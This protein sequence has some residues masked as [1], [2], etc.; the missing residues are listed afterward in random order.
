MPR[1]VSRRPGHRP[2]A[3]VG[4][5]APRMPSRCL[6]CLILSPSV[7][8]KSDP[9][10][11]RPFPIPPLLPLFPIHPLCIRPF[12]LQS[13]THPFFLLLIL[14]PSILSLSDPL[15]IRPFPVPPLPIRPFPIPP[16]HPSFPL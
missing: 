12:P 1:S 2:Q 4:V 11:I 9:L 10:P 3:Q 13:S 7:L 15:P 6:G 14:S 8:S 16:L 5:Q